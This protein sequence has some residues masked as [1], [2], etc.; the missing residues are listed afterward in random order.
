MESHSPLPGADPGLSRRRVL[1]T[2]GVVGAAGAFLASTAVLA[3]AA[4]NAKMRW[5]I[6]NVDFATSTLLAGG[7]ASARA[8]DNSKITVTG[9]GTFRS[10]P[11]NPQDVTGGGIW[12]TFSPVGA[13]TG[14]GTYNV[15]GLVGFHVA[16]GTAPL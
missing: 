9:S 4:D 12:E 5:D 14:R 8:N 2:M 11:G 6:V 13:S 15:T 10:N 7:Q 3:E 16:P 1:K